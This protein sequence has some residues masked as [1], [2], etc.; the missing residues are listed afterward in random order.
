MQTDVRKVI[1]IEAAISLHQQAIDCISQVKAD[2]PFYWEHNRDCEFIQDNFLHVSWDEATVIYSCS[3]CF[4]QS[5]LIQIGNKINH[6]PNINKVFSL[7]PL[8]TITMPLKGV[9]QVECSWD[10]ALCFFYSQI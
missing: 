3:T 9:F 8:P 6:T 4:T 2:L 7:R 10:S 1:G 5:L